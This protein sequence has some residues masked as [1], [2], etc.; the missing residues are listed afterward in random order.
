MQMHERMMAAQ[1]ANASETW[2]RKM[3]EHHRGAIEMSNVLVNQGGEQ[4]VVEK[5]RKT[6]ED[7]RREIQELERML[8][9]DESD[10]ERMESWRGSP[11]GTDMKEGGSSGF[12]GVLGGWRDAETGTY[13]N[14]GFY[15]GFWTSTAVATFQTDAVEAIDRGLLDPYSSVGRFAYDLRAGLAVRCVSDTLVND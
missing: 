10:V 5:A 12:E 13:K 2:V 6:A 9:M 8:G 11:I 15:G 7:Q 1:G 14:Y 4:A 3:I